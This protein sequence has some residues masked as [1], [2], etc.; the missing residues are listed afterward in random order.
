MAH[1]PAASS[2]FITSSELLQRLTA[3]LRVVLGKRLKIK[4]FNQTGSEDTEG[5]MDEPCFSSQRLSGLDGSRAEPQPPPLMMM[6]V[7]ELMR[8][9]MITQRLSLKPGLIKLLSVWASAQI[10]ITERE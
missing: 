2:A 6:M 10:V 8:R 4:D 1:S 5:R 9:Q 7:C 3:A